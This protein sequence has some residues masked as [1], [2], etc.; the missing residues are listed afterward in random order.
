MGGINIGAFNMDKLPEY[1]K[2][3][4]SRKVAIVGTG[5]VGG[6]ALEMLIKMGVTDIYAFDFDPFEAENT[7]KSSCLYRFPD[8][9]GKNKAVCIAQRANEILKSNSVHGIN[10]NITCFGPMAFA[11]FDIVILALDNYAA[12]VYFNQIW[13]QIP[14]TMRPVLIFGGTVGESAQS[15]CLDGND[16]CLRC[17]LA[18]E[19]LGNPLHRTSC[20][21]PQYRMEEDNAEIVRTTGLASRI[22][23]DLMVE[24]CRSIFLGETEVLNKRLMY[25]PYPMIGL[26]Q[27]RPMRRKSCPDC[28]GYHM[29]ENAK[30]LSGMDVLHSTVGDL[31]NVLETDFEDGRF[32]VTVPIIEFAKIAYNGLI[33]KD[34]CRGCGRE[35]TG[36]YQHEFRT[37]D[38]D[39]MCGEC[40]EAERTFDES[41]SNFKVGTVIKAIAKSNCTE[42][43]KKKTL[44]EVGFIIGGFIEVIHRK[45]DCLDVMDQGM[46]RQM[47]YCEND[48]VMLDK[49]TVLEG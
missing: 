12:K 13:R 39:I 3:F 14:G 38:S 31:L 41:K 27:A 33:E 19:W 8:D 26:T 16:A 42:K 46:V 47:Y 1:I 21:G 32:E 24:Q 48:Q 36:V 43:L 37:K 18:E 28:K 29:I 17:L 44:F 49:I 11:G 34:Y 9:V 30:P 2:D 6:Y 5:A 40:R 23:A 45:P 35:L 20:T 7:S 4:N 10:A 15:N 25:N 22:S